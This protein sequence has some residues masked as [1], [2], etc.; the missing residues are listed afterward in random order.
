MQNYRSQGGRVTLP[1]GATLGDQ[2]LLDTV[3]VPSLLSY[4]SDEAPGEWPWAV[5]TRQVDGMGDRTRI[6]EAVVINA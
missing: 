5:R 2:Y 3:D 4:I 1:I 6:S